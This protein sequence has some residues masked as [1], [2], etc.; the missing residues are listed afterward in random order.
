LAPNAPTQK[1]VS[2]A[3]RKISGGSAA[4]HL[5]WRQAPTKMTYESIVWV[6][7]DLYYED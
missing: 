3:K 1:G 5:G 7:L 4:V 6:P 2:K